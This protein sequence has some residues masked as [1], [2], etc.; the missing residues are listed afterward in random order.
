MRFS[1]H[2]S[3]L[4]VTSCIV[5]TSHFLHWKQN[6]CFLQ[7]KTFTEDIDVCLAPRYENSTCF[8]ICFTSTT[9]SSASWPRLRPGVIVPGLTDRNPSWFVSQ[10]FYESSWIPVIPAVLF[11]PVITASVSAE[12]MMAWAHSSFSVREDSWNSIRGGAVRAGCRLLRLIA[13][14]ICWAARRIYPSF[15]VFMKTVLSVRVCFGKRLLFYPVDAWKSIRVSY[16]ERGREDFVKLL[17]PSRRFLIWE[18]CTCLL[19]TIQI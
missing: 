7:D 6:D 11:P 9:V 14:I 3:V 5:W 13:L 10:C 15:Q 4:H 8:I 1:R 19:L 18:T 16:R 17:S 12:R 2:L